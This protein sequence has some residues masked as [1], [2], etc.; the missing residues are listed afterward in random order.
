[1][2]L[3]IALLILLVLTLSSLNNTFGIDTFGCVP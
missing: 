3:S 2:P 1:L